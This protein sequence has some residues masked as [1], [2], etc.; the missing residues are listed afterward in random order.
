MDDRS[1]VEGAVEA[2]N[3][4]IHQVG[5][6]VVF[7]PATSTETTE[8]FPV[9]QENQIVAVIPTSAA[10]GLSAIG[11]FVFRVALATDVLI[12]SGIEATHAKLDY[13]RV[14][15]IYDESDHF[16]TDSDEALSFVDSGINAL[17]QVKGQSK[18][19]L[20]SLKN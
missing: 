2:F 11:D 3:K 6:S 8:A 5:V 12:T 15:T 18:R 9:G 16:S 19:I 1:S 14:A 17:G 13:Q 10:R 4:L 20:F 7:G